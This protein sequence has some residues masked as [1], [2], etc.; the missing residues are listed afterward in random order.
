[1][2]H[3]LL[4]H[5]EMRVF[6]IYLFGVGS[7]SVYLCW[8]CTDSHPETDFGTMGKALWLRWGSE[9]SEQRQRSPWHHLWWA[10]PPQGPTQAAS[11]RQGVL[12]HFF[13]IPQTHKTSF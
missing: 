8:F 1:M 7:R 12:H 9:M 10:T 13:F 11:R 5:L 4:W 2:S 6:P 3:C